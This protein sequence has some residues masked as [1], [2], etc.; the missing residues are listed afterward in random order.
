[1]TGEEVLAIPMDPDTN[2]AGAD[3]IKGYLKRL[4]DLLWEEGNDFSG[5]RPFGNSG[6][7]YELIT[8][9]VQA[10]AIAG[11]LDEDGFINECDINAGNKLI[12]LAI[13][14]L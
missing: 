1:M 12:F 14:A 11:T 5:K 13:A 6:W 7:D 3:S 9:L 4:L 10:K 8:A 2:D